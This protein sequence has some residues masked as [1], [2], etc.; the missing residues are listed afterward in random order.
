MILK[1]LKAVLIC[2]L[3]SFLLYELTGIIGKEML[4]DKHIN[5]KG[6]GYCNVVFGKKKM[7]H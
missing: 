7:S 3:L 6:K 1:E 2:M 5:G 4:S